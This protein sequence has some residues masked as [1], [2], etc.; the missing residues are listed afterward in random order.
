MPMPPPVSV[1]PLEEF[2]RHPLADFYRQRLAQS[3]SESYRGRKMA[4][5]PED[6]RTYQHIIEDTQ[7]EVIVELGTHEGGS[8]QWFADQSLL[9]T[10]RTYGGS[11]VVTVDTHQRGKPIDDPAIRFIQGSLTDQRV[12]DEVHREVGGRRAMVVEDSAHTY[13]ITIQALTLYSGLV[14]SGCYFVVEDGAVDEPAIVPGEWHHRGVQKAVTRFCEE[15]PDFER[16]WLAPYGITS[17]H[18]GWLKRR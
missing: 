18:G 15:R 4:K 12:V 5:L 11:V 9:L 14:A 16:Q 7:P 1:E 2:L 13:D 6:L 10:P 8:A 17:N 3:V